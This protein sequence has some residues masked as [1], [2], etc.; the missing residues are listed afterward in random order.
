MGILLRA[1]DDSTEIMSFCGGYKHTSVKAV[2]SWL[3]RLPKVI[4][5]H[6]HGPQDQEGWPATE[7]AV[8]YG[9]HLILVLFNK[10]PLW[11]DS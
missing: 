1:S 6:L 2:D 8:Y 10:T 5:A 9:V 11:I 7:E 3:L 4:A